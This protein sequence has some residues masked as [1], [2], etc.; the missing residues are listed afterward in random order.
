MK[1]RVLYPALALFV[2]IATVSITA[3]ASDPNPV[4]T[5]ES[6]P[7]LSVPLSDATTSGQSPAPSQP[8]APKP[9][10]ADQDAHKVGIGFV[11][12]TLGLGGQGAVGLNWKLDIRGELNFFR[13]SRST[14]RNGITYDASIHLGNVGVL[15]DWFP[16][17]NG[18]HLSP[19]LLVYNGNEITGGASV[20]GGLPFTLNGTVYFA[21]T[22]NPVTGS[23]TIGLNKVAPEILLGWGTLLPSNHHW[24]VIFD[25]GVLFWGSPNVTMNLTGDVCSFGQTNCR[26]ISSDPTVQANIKAQEQKYTNDASSYKVFPVIQF[27]VGYRF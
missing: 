2:M 8:A 1:A 10:S 15:L 19:G 7:E 3:T 27:G 21:S 5:A 14:V 22:T 12:G 9:Q 26:S 23:A 4:G 24:S 6:S 18:F 17:A 11:F 13:I 16:W 25:A 20:K